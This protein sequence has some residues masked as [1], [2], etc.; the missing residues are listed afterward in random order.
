MK[1][2]VVGKSVSGLPILCHQWESNGP[3]ILILA[4]VHGDEIEGIAAAYG[5]FDTLLKNPIE[6]AKISI[7]PMLNM[8]GI[9]AKTRQNLNGID[10]N[11]NM[12][13]KDWTSETQN[14]RYFPGTQP[15][16]EPETQTL[17][18]FISIQKP[19]FIYNLHSWKPLLNVNGD[20]KKEAQ[21]ISQLTNY[22]IHEDIGYPTPGCLG[23][24]CGLER[25]IPT[26]T[27]EIERGLSSENILKIHV[28]AILMALK[29]AHTLLKP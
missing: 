2:I 21:I 17:V 19:R 23:T 18:N 11:R 6:S 3:H 8:D 28:P 25:N 5:I 20:C 9:L 26:L 16:S 27:Y 29:S 1:S 4:G 13:T 15:D 10:L 22:E 14:P 24:Y 12:S 7:I